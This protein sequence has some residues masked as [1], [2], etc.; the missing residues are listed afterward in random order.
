MAAVHPG[1]LLFLHTANHDEVAFGSRLE[2]REMCKHWQTRK[3][4]FDNQS[5]VAVPPLAFPCEWIFATDIQHQPDGHHARLCNKA[6]RCLVLL[7]SST[8]SPYV[9][10]R[11]VL[12]L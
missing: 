10:S 8:G 3:P 6:E 11:R 12:T 7:C 9:V 2:S 4:R 5:L 1:A